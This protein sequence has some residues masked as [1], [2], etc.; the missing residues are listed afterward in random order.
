MLPLRSDL[1]DISRALGALVT[2]GADRA[3]PAPVCHRAAE[4]CRCR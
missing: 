1:G 2:D 3:H 4:T